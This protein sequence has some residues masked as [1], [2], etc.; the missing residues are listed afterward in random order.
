[1]AAATRAGALPSTGRVPARILL[2]MAELFPA[3]PEE[4]L[5]AL[6]VDS[7]E[8]ID[9][10]IHDGELADFFARG[11]LLARALE[12]DSDP[13]V[14]RALVAHWEARDHRQAEAHAE[15]WR[16]AYP[17]D[18]EPLLRLV[19]ATEARGAHQRA[20]ELLDRA[21]AIDPMHPELRQSR[22]RL[23]LTSAERRIR[24][25]DTRGSGGSRRPRQGDGRD[26][27]RDLGL[28]RRA[29]VAGHA[30]ERRRSRGRAAPR[31]DRVAARQS[32]DA[33]TGHGLGGRI[34]RPRATRGPRG[35]V[36]RRQRPGAGPRRRPVPRAG[37][38]ARRADRAAGRRRAEP[39]R[40]IPGR[41]AL[42]VCRR[43]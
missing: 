28:S 42:P 16:R 3:D 26:E 17:A 15:A 30:P 18:L 39:R 20:L 10:L 21:E 23:L 40:S 31:G 1:M 13:R 9:E 22:V 2:H 33:L 29:P 7:E 14:F 8:E 5:D 37:P 34:V 41:S 43:T 25:D 4:V 35:R 38:P 24:R 36:A 12:A 19:R 11:R 27:R 32:H 6:G